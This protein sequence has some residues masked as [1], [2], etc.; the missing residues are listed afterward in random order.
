MNKMISISVLIISLV[1]LYHFVIR[2]I[3]QDRKLE[4]CLFGAGVTLGDGETYE[5]YEKACIQ[6]Y[7]K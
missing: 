6:K 4:E 1:F 2:P 3:Q 5:D 7:G